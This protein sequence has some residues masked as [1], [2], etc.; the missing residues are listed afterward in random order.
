MGHVNVSI[1]GRLYRMACEDGEEERLEALARSF[2]E[3][4][5]EL[6]R[7]VG[8]IGDRRLTVMAGL[9]V[10]DRLDEATRRVTELEREL[11]TARAEAA[12]SRGTPS[13]GDAALAEKLAAATARID[14]LTRQLNAFVRQGEAR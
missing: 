10:A 12:A 5:D 6:R 13:G 8:E 7:G 11:R 14:E 9:L 2:D 3:V 1:G 4:V